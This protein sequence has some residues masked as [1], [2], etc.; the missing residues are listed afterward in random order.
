MLDEADKK[1]LERLKGAQPPAPT[2]T[3][4]TDSGVEWEYAL[5]H[6]DGRVFLGYTDMGYD[7]AVCLGFYGY[8]RVI[9]RKG[10]DKWRDWFGGNRG[11]H[12]SSPFYKKNRVADPEPTQ[13]VWLELPEPSPQCGQTEVQESV[14][15]N[16]ETL[17]AP[18]PDAA[19]KLESDLPANPANPANTWNRYRM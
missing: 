18:L 8:R 13:R 5:K 10:E 7:D 15:P 4:E 14:A 19:L 17:P 1:K 16:P 2:P 9:R 11:L 12:P 6:E 3:I